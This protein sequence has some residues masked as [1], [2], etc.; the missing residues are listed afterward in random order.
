MFNWWRN[1]TI[2]QRFLVR[3]AVGVAAFAPVVA[4]APGANAWLKA[5][6]LIEFVSLIAG[7]S[8]LDDGFAN[9]RPTSRSGRAI[10]VW[11]YGPWYFREG[12]GERWVRLAFRVFGLGLMAFV[13]FGI[14]WAAG[15]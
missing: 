10:R 5:I 1:L 4:S 6:V 3:G 11:M 15:A 7:Y 12:D 8:A 13:A 9:W 14:A 2:P